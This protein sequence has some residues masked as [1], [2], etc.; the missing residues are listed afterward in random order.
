MCTLNCILMFP[1]SALLA[2]PGTLLF[3]V[4][5]TFLLE[6]LARLQNLLGSLELVLHFH[7]LLQLLVVARPVCVRCGLHCGISQKER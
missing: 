5:L 1:L 4:S 6:Q 2:L 7:L 3:A